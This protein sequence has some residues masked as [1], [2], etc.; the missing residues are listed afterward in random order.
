[1]EPYDI[2]A[3]K[4]LIGVALTAPDRV[5]AEF[6]AV[7]AD[8]WFT[9]S[10]RHIA[11]VITGM[12]AHDSPVDPYTVLV[13]AQARGL[14]PGRV[15]PA[16]V[17]ECQQAAGLPESASLHAQRIRDLSAA[18]RL[19]QAGT[20]LAQR[21]ESAWTTGADPA[22]IAAAVTEA[23]R[24]CDEAEQIGADITAS[25][26]TPM[27]DFL[28]VTDTH[29][30]LV[31]GL[32]ERMDRIVLTGAEGGGKA[33]ALDTPIPTPKG[34]TTMG[35]LSIGDE[36]FHADGTPV[37]IIAATE[38][39]R[40]RPCYRL[41]FSD[42]AQI[43]A[44]EQHLWLTDTLASREADAKARR[45]GPLKPRGTDQSHKR[46]HF[47][48]VRTT[49]EIIETLSA[50]NGHTPN[51]SVRVSQPLQ[52]PAQELPIHPYVLGAW[53]GDGSSYHSG[54]TCADPE[55]INEIRKC[56]EPVKHYGSIQYAIT[57][58]D[59][60]RSKPATFRGRLRT[61]GV[62][63]NKHIPA[64]YLQSSV[65]QRMALLRGLMDTDGSIFGKPGT[66]R[67]TGVKCEFSVTSK[68][69]AEGF[70][71]LVLGLGIKAVMREGAA[72]LNGREV[73]RRY[74]IQF[75]TDAPVFRLSRK[76][77]LI[78]PLRTERSRLRYITGVEPIDSVPVRCIKVDRPD[79]LFIAARE[80]IV[81]HNS[82]ACTQIAC[83]LAAGLHP[84]TGNPLGSG[85]RRC[86]VLIVD[87][88][89]SPP[90]SR[91][92]YKWV[93]GLVDAR[94]HNHGLSAVD[95]NDCADIEI[96]PAGIDLLSGADTAKLERAIEASAPDL[97]VLGPLYKLHHENPN[98]EKPARE[99]AWVLDGLRERHGFALLTEAH[100]GK[101]NAGDGRRNMAPIGSSMWMRW[102]E[103]GFGLL[104]SADDKSSGRAELV[105]VVSWRGSREERSWPSKLQHSHILP[106]M[107]A[108]PAYYDTLPRHS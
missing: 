73:S 31:P 61:L 97:L 26:P 3:E 76:L 29:D 41:T 87:C 103:F 69:L 82:V 33:L 68:A 24:A 53:L 4:A 90:Q 35:E 59:Q 1:M 39:M 108:D 56:G 81:T 65:E 77:S 60:T 16:L 48:A 88:E 100:A 5:R 55:I 85:T 74:R 63:K 78:R 27:G 45:R 98:D 11:V 40:D 79:G 6:L 96:R 47:A 36:V 50:R 93:T 42:G 80:C 95:W 75:R 86:R 17:L 23:R 66:G 21:M 15:P 13:E 54:F 94:R 62:L 91:R 8:D 28:S 37:R 64:S 104:R 25:A 19:S 49:K 84:F 67:G 46:K 106:W 58:G 89:N 99:V 72:K 51:H 102:P 44:D 43:V 10:L 57:D 105:D 101:S 22:D 2:T 7:R 34:W 14:V 70:L 30:W 9:P 32:L 38:V 92:R 20:R 71:E 12:F 107:P 83:T 52:Y 18:R